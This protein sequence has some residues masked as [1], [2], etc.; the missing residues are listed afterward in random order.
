M[1]ERLRI[2][3]RRL[4]PATR[5]WKVKISCPVSRSVSSKGGYHLFTRQLCSPAFCTWFCF[6]R[7]RNYVH[8]ISRLPCPQAW[9]WAQPMQSN[10]RGW[11][12]G[13]WGEGIYIPPAFSLH[14]CL[15]LA[16][17]FNQR[18]QYFSSWSPPHISPFPGSSNHL[19]PFPLKTRG[20]NTLLHFS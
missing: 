7:R 2:H 3:E 8:C 20:D 9:V 15:R 16:I 12:Q 19:L 5:P 1:D 6:L 18:L 11:R 14:S 4:R 17:T 13:E 10:S